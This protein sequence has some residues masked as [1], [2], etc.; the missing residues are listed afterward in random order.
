[1]ISC[2][3][4]SLCWCDN[5][6]TNYDTT[7][8]KCY[9]FTT[10][11]FTSQWQREVWRA[12][13]PRFNP[14]FFLNAWNQAP[15]ERLTLKITLGAAPSP[16]RK[17]MDLAKQG[18]CKKFYMTLFDCRTTFDSN[19]FTKFRKACLQR[20]VGEKKERLPLRGAWSVPSQEQCCTS[21]LGGAIYCI[22]FKLDL[23]WS[24]IE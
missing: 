12:V 4:N 20:L 8:C 5:C 1:M 15:K 10:D 11:V 14:P 21:Y 13:K 6:F 17:R 9:L 7:A 23:T 16:L 22:R 18:K 2:V 19:N 24:W 3:N